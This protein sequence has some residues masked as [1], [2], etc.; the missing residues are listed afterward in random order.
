VEAAA[1]ALGRP[2]SLR[3]LVVRGEGRGRE[4]GFPTANLALA[5]SEK[6]VPAT[7]IYAVRGVVG[8]NAYHGALHLG[9]RP[10]FAGSAPSI[11]LHLIDY[12][13]DLYGEQVRV[14]FVRR[15]REVRPFD[16]VEALVAQMREDVAQARRILAA[17][18]GKG[19]G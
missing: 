7:G 17:Q 19:R 15:L 14:E 10:T 4:L 9:P 11:E 18:G 6:L 8:G 16:G 3:G 5:T 13:G 2:Y 12:A 1:R